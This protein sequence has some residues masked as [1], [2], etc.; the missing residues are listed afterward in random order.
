M[1]LLEYDFWYFVNKI[2]I[3]I[4]I[5]S[6]FC[7]RSANNINNN[8][9]HIYVC[10]YE[11]NNVKI[12]VKPFW[13]SRKSGGRVYYQILV[14][15]LSHL[16]TSGSG[17][18]CIGAADVECGPGRAGKGIGSGLRGP[19]VVVPPPLRGSSPLSH[20][21]TTSTTSRVLWGG[22]STNLYTDLHTHLL[23]YQTRMDPDDQVRED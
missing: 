5:I 16:G 9:V 1:L 18:L 10:I 15:S 13:R 21:V 12:P 6:G 17:R 23:T 8:D 7:C 3:I 14:S 22:S 4:K 19:V 20:S 11:Y 2:L